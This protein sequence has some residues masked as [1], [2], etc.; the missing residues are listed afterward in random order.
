MQRRHNTWT[1]HDP[2]AVHLPAMALPQ[3]GYQGFIQTVG[4]DRIPVY[5][6]RGPPRKRLGHGRWRGKIHVRYPQR[7][8]VRRTKH[9]LAAV[10]FK[11]GGTGPIDYAI[12]VIMA[13]LACVQAT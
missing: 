3:P 10:V 5:R 9:V 4:I 1:H 12:E 8:N 7:D 2:V 11:A 6:M 13:D